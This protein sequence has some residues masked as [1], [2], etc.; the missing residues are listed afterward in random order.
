MGKNGIVVE[1]SRAPRRR[2]LVREWK[3]EQIPA[4]CAMKQFKMREI[5]YD[6]ERLAS[7]AAEG[8]ASGVELT[9]ASAWFSLVQ[10]ERIRLSMVE[11]DRRPVNR[12]GL[13]FIAMDGWSSKTMRFV[14]RAFS[15]L[16][17]PKEDELALFDTGG[18]I[19]DEIETT[20]PQESPDIEQRSLG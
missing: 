14:E 12:D 9:N 18:A 4:G 8:S 5:D 1:Q 6:D 2:R 20:P 15:K 11:V 7:M 10:R 13:P 3:D 16:N 19:C 17:M